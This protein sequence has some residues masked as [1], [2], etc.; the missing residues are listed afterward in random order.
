MEGLKVVGDLLTSKLILALNVL[1]ER[2]PHSFSKRKKPF[3]NGF[4]QGVLKM[5]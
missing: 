4:K 1:I 2:F 3:V 5:S